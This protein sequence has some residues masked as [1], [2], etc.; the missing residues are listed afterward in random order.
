VVLVRLYAQ[1]KNV[2]TKSKTDIFWN[3]AQRKAEGESYYD[4]PFYV[5][6]WF[7]TSF[8]ENLAKG[9]HLGFLSSTD[10]NI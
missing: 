1:R 5:L 4:I 3:G 10:A 7:K 8:Y 2:K 9:M 6:W